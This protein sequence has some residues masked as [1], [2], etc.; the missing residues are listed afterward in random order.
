MLSE[1][2]ALVKVLERGLWFIVLSSYPEFPVLAN[3][4]DGMLRHGI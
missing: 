4:V 1:S 3:S 2:Y